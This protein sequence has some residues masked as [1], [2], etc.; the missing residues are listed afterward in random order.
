MKAA[1]YIRV[2]TEDQARRGYSLNEQ[3]DTCEAKAVE[4]G[5]KEIRV[6]AD[7]GVS[8]SLLDRPGLNLLRD[9]IRTERAELLV[10]RDPDRLSRRLSHQLLLTEEMDR[11]GV[12]MHFLDFD[13][14]DTPDGRLFYAIRGAIAE[15]EKEKIRE[16]MQ[17]GRLQKARQGGIPIGFNTYGY[18]YQRESGK[19]QPHP[20]ESILVAEIFELFV[21]GDLGLNGIARELNNRGEVSHRGRDWQ[22]QVIRKMISNPVYKG[23]WSYKGIEISVPPL[24]DAGIWE[25][26]QKKLIVSRRMWAGRSRLGYLLSGIAVCGDC[27]GSLNGVLVNWWGRKERRYTCYKNRPDK[28][29]C[30]CR[31]RNFLPSI[32]LEQAVWELVKHSFND[33]EE[34]SKEIGYSVHDREGL[35]LEVATLRKKIMELDR[36]RETVIDSLSSG[37]LDLNQGI[38]KR[39]SEI[40]TKKIKMEARLGQL[41]ELLEA[42]EYETTKQDL[43][44]EAK[45]ILE[46]I[47]YLG[48]SDRRAVLRLVVKRV[49]VKRVKDGDF[50]IELTVYARLPE[51]E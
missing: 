29:N 20:V 8:G 12:E 5:A 32:P 35:E 27:G 9:F 10:V 36:R 40:K 14:N 26:A 34:L 30:G 22:R 11:L 7:E 3:R 23:S 44:K 1:V 2:S 21:M 51:E 31:P 28:K 48:F 50:A 25:K 38:K 19:L 41:E 47:D 15:Y 4:L 24:V 49:D 42:V 43:M 6:F 18:I 46:G 33:A 39:L 16:R 37:L 17:R 45:C 13:W